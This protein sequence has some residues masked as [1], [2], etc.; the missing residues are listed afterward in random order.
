VTHTLRNAN[1]P[2]GPIEL[3]KDVAKSLPLLKS[4]RSGKFGMGNYTI[5][6]GALAWAVSAGGIPSI[7]RIVDD[8]EE[9][10]FMFLTLV[11]EWLSRTFDGTRIVL[12]HRLWLRCLILVLLETR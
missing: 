1:V 3:A 8:C 9:F 4:G 2:E 5:P 6:E 11:V 7:S 12:G 10:I